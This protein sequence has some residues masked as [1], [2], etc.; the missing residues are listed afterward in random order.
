MSHSFSKVSPSIWMFGVPASKLNLSVRKYVK[1]L[2]AIQIEGIDLMARLDFSFVC[3][4]QL[5]ELKQIFWNIIFLYLEL[6]QF[7]HKKNILDPASEIHGWPG[8]GKTHFGVS[9]SN[10]FYSVKYIV[11]SGQSS[12][13]RVCFTTTNCLIKNQHIIVLMVCGYAFV[14]PELILLH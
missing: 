4:G 13:L 12:R 8:V 11:L 7:T 14:L 10:S 5:F 9:D 2:Q 1:C 3:P 6:Y